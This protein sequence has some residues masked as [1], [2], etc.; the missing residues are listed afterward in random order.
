[1]PIAI[2]S[3][4]CDTSG[5]RQKRIT[6]KTGDDVKL[7]HEGVGL[8]VAEVAVLKVRKLFRFCFEELGTESHAETARYLFSTGLSLGVALCG[9]DLDTTERVLKSFA[10][11]LVQLTE[12]T[13]GPI[14]E[15]E[16]CQTKSSE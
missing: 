6:N 14:E 9:D 11:E 3:D 16:P 5:V 4:I 7:T 10:Q 12:E 8:P 13:L 15:N 1:M 2:S